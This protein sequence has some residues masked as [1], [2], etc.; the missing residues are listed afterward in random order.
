M[1]HIK[2]TF[3]LI[4]ILFISACGYHLRTGMTLP[5]GLNK[6]Y[7]L[8]GSEPLRKSFKKMLRMINGNLVE[9]GEDADL[10]VRILSEKMDSR[11]LSL[12]NTGRVNE[13]ELVYNLSFILLDQDGE[14]LKEEQSVEIRKEYFNDQGDILAANNEADTIRKEMYD[15]AVMAVARNAWA[16]LD[17]E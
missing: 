5:E 13:V 11:V 8:Q 1:I 16:F 4:S 12:N 10:I 2:S 6:V 17:T 9:S 7:L 14:E 15:E 3:L